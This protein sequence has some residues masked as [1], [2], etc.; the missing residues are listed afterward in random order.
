MMK[1]MISYRTIKKNKT[2]GEF[3]PKEEVKKKAKDKE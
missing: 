2:L 3:T 1:S